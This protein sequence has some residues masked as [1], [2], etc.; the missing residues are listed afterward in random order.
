MLGAAHD[1]GTRASRPACRDQPLLEQVQLHGELADLALE[2]GALRRVGPSVRPGRPTPGELASLVLP[3]PDPQQL[4]GD[5]VPTRQLA[6]AD[7]PR[8][9]EWCRRAGPQLGSEPART[10]TAGS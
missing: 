9:G 4:A 2:P 7:R 8:P 6:Q 10:A 1:G 3:H 5:I